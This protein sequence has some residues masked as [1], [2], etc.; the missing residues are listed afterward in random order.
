VSTVQ[1]E[2]ATL[3]VVKSRHYFADHDDLEVL[4]FLK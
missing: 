3:E 4:S 2:K 1:I